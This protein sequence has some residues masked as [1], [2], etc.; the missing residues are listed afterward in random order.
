MG[1]LAAFAFTADGRA[2]PLD[3]AGLAHR[4]LTP[5][6]G[7]FVWVH[8]QIEP[9][10]ISGWLHSHSDLGALAV[11][12]LNA[13]E[14]RP[15]CTVMGDG[16]LLILRGVNLSEGAE[17]EDMVSLRLWITSDLV[18]SVQ[19]RA[20]VAVEDVIEECRRQTGPVAPGDLLAFPRLP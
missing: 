20:L 19:R 5:P 7:G 4:D 16:V 10:D 18:V 17:P 3:I 2:A 12:A 9:G 6:E 8:L 11:G 1:V 13:P 15:R 14:T